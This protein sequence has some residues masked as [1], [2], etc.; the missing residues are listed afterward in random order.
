MSLR[1]SLAAGVSKS[2]LSP[3]GHGFPC[4][5]GLARPAFA[6]TRHQIEGDDFLFEWDGNTDRRLGLAGDSGRICNGI[7]ALPALEQ[8]PMRCKRIGLL[9]CC[10]ILR[11]KKWTIKN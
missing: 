9:R 4:Q 8:L 7:R 10:L 11:G 3:Q 2:Q 1:E 5:E 6:H